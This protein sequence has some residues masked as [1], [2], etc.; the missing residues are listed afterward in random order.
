MP[1]HLDNKEAFASN[2]APCPSEIAA[3]PKKDTLWRNRNHCQSMDPFHVHPLFCR[4]HHSH[5]HGQRTNPWLFLSKR[6]EAG[7]CIVDRKSIDLHLFLFWRATWKT[8]TTTRRP[9]VSHMTFIQRPTR[10]IT[11]A[12]YLLVY[13][14]TYISRILY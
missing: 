12:T 9:H 11:V 2:L 10:P 8:A 6:K 13:V 5:H 1:N 3:S 4:R 14:D 7:G